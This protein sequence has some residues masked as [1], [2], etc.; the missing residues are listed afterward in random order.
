MGTFGIRMTVPSAIAP[1]RTAYE[2]FQSSA[3]VL[4]YLW[5]KYCVIDSQ[6]IWYEVAALNNEISKV[7][8][9]G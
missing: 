3:L 9:S 2:E 8:I 7:L 5:V 1:V 4:L 6:P